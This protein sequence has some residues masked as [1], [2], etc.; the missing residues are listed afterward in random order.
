M[1]DSDAAAEHGINDLTQALTE[2]SKLWHATVA[3]VN[4]SLE[5][6][7]QMSAENEERLLEAVFVSG[8]GKARVGGRGGAR[9]K[10]RGRLVREGRDAQTES[11]GVL[12][13]RASEREH[14]QMKR[15]RENISGWISRS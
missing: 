5:Q 2:H 10:E 9:R 3:R 8:E 6:Q 15:H 7:R 12:A 13:L 4:A 11:A 1:D 14:G